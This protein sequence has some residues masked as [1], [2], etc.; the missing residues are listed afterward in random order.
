LSTY[1]IKRIAL[2]DGDWTAIVA[3]AA[4][5]AWALRN[6]SGGDVTIATTPKDMSTHDNLAAGNS[7]TCFYGHSRPNPRF[8]EGDVLLYAKPASGAGILTGRFVL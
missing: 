4:C 5:T 6:D 3:P 1:L 8:L 7:E 2:A